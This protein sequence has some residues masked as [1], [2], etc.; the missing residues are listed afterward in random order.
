MYAEL[1]ARSYSD[2]GLRQVHQLVV[3][4]YAAQHAGGTS[5]RQVQT[6]ALCLMTLCL[7]FENDVD[8]PKAR[9]CT[10]RWSATARRSAGCSHPHHVIC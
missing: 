5:R 1:L 6:V 7:V 8:P 10:S 2:P 3:D 4:A 9:G